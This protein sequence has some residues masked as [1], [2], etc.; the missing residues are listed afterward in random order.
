MQIDKTDKVDIVWNKI[1]GHVKII[2]YIKITWPVIEGKSLTQYG[3]MLYYVTLVNRHKNIFY[4]LCYSYHASAAQTQ[5]AFLK[6]TLSGTDP[7]GILK[8]IHW[9]A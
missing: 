5:T 3:E 1:N 6:K 4:Q 7:N 2:Y 8:K 9:K